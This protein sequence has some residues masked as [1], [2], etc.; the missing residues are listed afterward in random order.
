MTSVDTTEDRYVQETI[1]TQED[2][3][4]KSYNK[5]SEDLYQSK[6]SSSSS[7]SEENIATLEEQ[8]HHVEA[9]KDEPNFKSKA[10]LLRFTVVII[11]VI[12]AMFM[13]SLNSTVVAPALSI[14]ATDL[15]ALASQTWIATA[16]LVAVNAFQPLSG[17][18]KCLYLVNTLFY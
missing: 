11:G 16:Y 3:K 15:N 18:V 14:I 5:S 7:N 2:I 8:K 4:L 6:R 10:E 17:K 9:P 1:T 13:M 12:L